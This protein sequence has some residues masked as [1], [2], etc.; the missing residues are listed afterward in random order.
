MMLRF[1]AR[2]PRL[3]PHSSFMSDAGH[4]CCP[5][6]IFADFA[7]I[8]QLSYP[9]MLDPYSFALMNPQLSMYSKLPSSTGHHLVFDSAAR[10]S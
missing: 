2:M 5:I 1:A 7:W 10:L 8:L 9:S 6:L 4:H 3:L